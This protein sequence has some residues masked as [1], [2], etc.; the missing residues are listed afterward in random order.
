MYTAWLI[1]GD[2]F[3]PN[4]NENKVLIIKTVLYQHRIER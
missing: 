3:Q 1:V 4:Q 2:I